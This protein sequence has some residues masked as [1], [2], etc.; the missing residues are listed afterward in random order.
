MI[1]NGLRFNGGCTGY[2]YLNAC[3][4]LVYF[5]LET[6][7]TRG[8]TR[9]RNLSCPSPTL[10]LLSEFYPRSKYI[11]KKGAEIWL[12][13]GNVRPDLW[14]HG[15]FVKAVWQKFTL[16]GSLHAFNLWN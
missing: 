16:F 5:N 2:M 7:I 4:T 6:F 13:F 15:W 1:E 3:E 12:E 14:C 11:F 8:G 10:P 9:M